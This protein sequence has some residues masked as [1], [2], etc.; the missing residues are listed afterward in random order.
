MGVNIG[1]GDE[2]DHVLGNSVDL[3]L[4]LEVLNDV[5]VQAL[6]AIQKPGA[7]AFQF[8]TVFGRRAVVFGPN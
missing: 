5:K 4:G 3:V 2:L 6:V 1:L 7:D 8:F